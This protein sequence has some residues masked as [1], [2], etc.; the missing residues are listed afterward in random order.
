MGSIAA[1]ETRVGPP[2]SVRRSALKHYPRIRRPE[3]RRSPQTLHLYGVMTKAMTMDAMSLP[4]ADAVVARAQKGDPVALEALYRA[5]STPVY[6]LARRICRT[7]EDAED[8]L[9]ETFYEVCRSIRN[10]RGDGSVWGW[11]R[12]VASSKALMRLRRNKYRDTDL[13]NDELA[14]AKGA[15]VALR[16]DL[17]SAMARLGDTARAVVWLHATASES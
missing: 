7:T 10:Y 5:Y 16:M 12:T 17:E 9:Q 8:V 1:L 3:V 2:V 6:N 15:S 11:I 14:P 13:L 4:D